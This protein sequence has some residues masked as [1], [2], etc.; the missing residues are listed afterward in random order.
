VNYVMCLDYVLWT[1]YFGLCLWT[2]YEEL[3]YV[4]AFIFYVIL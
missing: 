1:L 3:C 2:L 4:D